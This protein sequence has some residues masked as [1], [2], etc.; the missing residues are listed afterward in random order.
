MFDIDLHHPVLRAD[1]ASGGILW[2]A[3]NSQYHTCHCFRS[4]NMDTKYV[5]GSQ[6]QFK[7]LQFFVC[8]LA[9]SVFCSQIGVFCHLIKWEYKC[10]TKTRSHKK[11]GELVETRQWKLQNKRLGAENKRLFLS[12]LTMMQMSSRLSQII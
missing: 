2:S 6:L 5:H 4:L 10:S 12:C 9:F 3:F 8:F 1:E 11:T 7:P